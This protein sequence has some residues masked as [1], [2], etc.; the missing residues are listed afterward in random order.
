MYGGVI[1]FVRLFGA[2]LPDR[3]G[4]KR[5]VFVSLVCTFLGLAVAGLAP[6]LVVLLSGT[7]LYA[8]GQS[9]AFPALISMAVQAAPPSQRASAMSTVSVGF[10]AAFGVGA[11][12]AGSV[13]AVAGIRTA[14]IVGGTTALLGLFL[15]PKAPRSIQ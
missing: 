5:T 4:Y 2:R 6:T 11:I 15:V 3:F 9:L 13:A 12:A 14:I 1:A 10:D 7:V 8:L